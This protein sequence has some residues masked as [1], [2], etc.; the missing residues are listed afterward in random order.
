MSEENVEIVRS[1]LV[2][3]A[4][5]LGNP[6]EHL[7]LSPDVVWDPSTVGGWMG[8]ERYVGR[9]EFL[10]FLRD[11]VQP[12]EEWA[13]EVERISDAGGDLVL[14]V[15]H[16]HGRPRSGEV[17]VEMRYGIV[18]TVSGGQVRHAS[19]YASPEDAL[20]AVGLRE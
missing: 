10:E 19:V 3:F 15:L 1:L 12:Y 4:D 13:F 6:P 9:N 2:D 17:V 20:E 8:K 16:Q 11:W 14:A 18:Y 5:P 7:A